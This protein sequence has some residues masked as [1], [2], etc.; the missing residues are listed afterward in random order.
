[1]ADP[2]SLISGLGRPYPSTFSEF[3]VT[4]LDNGGVH[5][6]SSIVNHAFYQLAEGLP[7]AIGI[8]D[9]ASIFYRALTTK[10]TPLSD[11]FDARFAL[12]L[13][14]E[15]LFGQ[16]SAQALATAAAL[17]AVEIFD[18]PSNP[19]PA[20]TPEVV[21]PDSTLFTYW[22]SNA[23]AYFLGRLEPDID[24]P[25][26]SQLS[27]G[28]ILGPRASVDGA[29]EIAIFVN[30]QND[31]CFI[32]TIGG[33]QE[34]CAGLTG[35]IA[36]VAMAA[37]GETFGLVLLDAQGN[38]TN[39]ITVI[40]FATNSE[41]EYVLEAPV[42]DGVSSIQVVQ[43]DAMDFTKDPRLLVYD[44]FNIADFPLPKTGALSTSNH[45][46]DLTSIS[47]TL[48]KNNSYRHFFRYAF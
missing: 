31:A 5:V 40:D 27:V 46:F 9:A 29:G 21:G 15:E 48:L 24:P 37:D 17:D 1:M 13:S 22:D 7:N 6:N 2:G 36:S 16:G 43:A 23:A 41:I 25:Q 8:V 32:A 35:Q 39:R 33:I 38:P 45:T 42:F 30:D 11:F 18:A 10:L 3:E 19:L 4:A 14:A 47:T 26:G 28:P 20:P 44:A 12:I 34:S